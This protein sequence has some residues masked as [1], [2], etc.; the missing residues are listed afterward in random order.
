[1]PPP[2]INNNKATAQQ[3]SQV[4]CGKHREAIEALDRALKFDP[5][6]AN[7][8]RYRQ[9][10]SYL[11]YDYTNVLLYYDTEARPNH[12]NA[13]RYLQVSRANLRMY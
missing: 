5:R 10:S 12:A 9:V 2:I 7:A 6:H 13:A 4:T 3:K 11:V 1:M 8:A